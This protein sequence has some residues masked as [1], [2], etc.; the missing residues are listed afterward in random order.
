MKDAKYAIKPFVILASSFR[1]VI[2]MDADTLFLKN[3]KSL[4]EMEGYK[5]LGT[6]FFHDRRFDP[7]RYANHEFAENFINKNT[8]EIKQLS[9]FKYISGHEMESGVV[10]V[11]KGSDAFFGLLTTCVM[12]RKR[13]R[14]VA[15]KFMLGFL[16]NYMR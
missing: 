9:F 4:F 2:L 8:P 5:S 10:V 14:D 16:N 13:S 6:V 3:P 7:G 15:Y 11:N 12:N 1:E